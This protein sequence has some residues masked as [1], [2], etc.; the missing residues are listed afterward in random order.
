MSEKN[1]LDDF[2]WIFD[3]ADLVFAVAT[4]MQSA[5]IEIYKDLKEAIDKFQDVVSN[6]LDEE[7]I[8][9]KTR[10]ELRIELIR[11]TEERTTEIEHKI[12]VLKSMQKLKWILIVLIIPYWIKFIVNPES[13]QII[14]IT[15]SIYLLLGVAQL[16]LTQE[17]NKLSDCKTQLLLFKGL[18]LF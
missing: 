4:K 11:F 12:K 13:N 10:Q 5:D 6:R 2:K 16:L 15:I 9:G 3:E 8:S 14:A 17:I 1:N 18:N 7:S